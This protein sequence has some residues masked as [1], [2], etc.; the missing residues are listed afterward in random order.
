MSTVL[1]IR[2]FQEMDFLYSNAFHSFKLLTVVNV[3]GA[4]DIK[5][6]QKDD[7]SFLQEINTE[8][9]KN[10]FFSKCG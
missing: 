9:K 8:M 2:I 10:N 4:S 7:Y 6:T 3:N 5:L 1:I